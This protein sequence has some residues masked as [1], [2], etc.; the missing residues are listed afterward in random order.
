MAHHSQWTEWCRPARDRGGAEQALPSLA[1]KLGRCDVTLVMVQDDA[2]S[3][4]E[5]ER[6][7]RGGPKGTYGG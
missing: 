6:A 5:Q 2:Y 7:V 4:E 3:L 1:I